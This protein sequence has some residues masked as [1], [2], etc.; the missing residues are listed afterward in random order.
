LSVYLIDTS[1][2]EVMEE[3]SVYLYFQSHTYLLTGNW[4]W[5]L[6]CHTVYCADVMLSLP[7]QYVG[8]KG[9]I[10][11]DDKEHLA[12]SLQQAA[13]QNPSNFSFRIITTYGDVVEL[14]GEAVVATEGEPLIQTPDFK[15]TLEQ[16]GTEKQNWKESEKL[17]RALAVAGIAEKHT[18]TGSWYYNTATFET[19]FSDNLYRLYGLTPQS[20]NAHLKTFHSF[21]HPEDAPICTEAFEKA[22]HNRVPLHITFRITDALGEVKYLQLLTHWAFNEKGEQIMGGTVMDCTGQKRAEA[23]LEAATSAAAFL[24]EQIQ[25]SEQ[26]TGIGTWQINLFTRKSVFSDNYYRIHGLKPQVA[27]LNL[28]L[29]ANYAHPEDR[30]LVTEAFRRILHEHVCPDIEYR[31]IRSDGKTR[32]VQLRGKPIIRSQ[33]DLVMVGTIKD[34]TTPRMLERKEALLKEELAAQALLQQEVETTAGTSVWVTD[35]QTGKTA[36][37][38]NL[39]NLLGYRPNFV[40]L[41]QK[42]FVNFIHLDDKKRFTET[43]NLALQ[44]NTTHEIHFRLVVKGTVKYTKATFKTIAPEG[45]YLFAA[46]LQDVSH[47]T[48]LQQ[49]QQYLQQLLNGLHHSIAEKVFVTDR[50]NSITDMNEACRAHLVPKEQPVLQKNVFDIF[51]QLQHVDYRAQLDQVFSGKVASLPAKVILKSGGTGSYMLLPLADDAQSVQHVLHVIQDNTLAY[52]QQRKALLH[53]RLVE[54]IIEW[55]P[56]RVIVMDRHMNYVYWNR[57]CEAHY[58]IKKEEVIG[59]NI[60]EILPG[61]YDDPGYNEFKRTLSGEVVS[62]T[63]RQHAD[64]ELYSEV[65]LIPVSD[66]DHH[67]EYILW[68]A[69]D[70]TDASLLVS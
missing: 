39:Y 36:W 12:Q 53:I 46:I 54:S 32:Y 43:L 65:L 45:K 33:T 57:K 64:A 11:P 19:Y 42:Q 44:E 48:Q 30:P 18:N 35:L 31:I 47:E 10:H 66:N 26:M 5:N 8:T 6:H 37:S 63:A 52:S 50:N 3:K 27:N 56:G 20:L 51:P 58:G 17:R 61:F 49:Q 59:K 70:P 69:F 60:L 13:V 15:R 34:I 40:E 9:I 41:S 1:E 68:M 38:P 23:E 29:L 7:V 4:L 24:K 67:I 62:L 55:M 16:Y 2:T 14:K 28:D 21:L 22:Y 25:F